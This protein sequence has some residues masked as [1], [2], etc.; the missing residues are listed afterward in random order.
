MFLFNVY[1]LLRERQ[2]ER[3]RERER[4]RMCTSGVEGREIEG[5]ESQ[6]GSRLSAHSPMYARL[7]LMN[8]EI[9]QE[10]DT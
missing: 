10:S 7:K 9:I 1:L 5:D 4:E 3:E 6:A 8:H 2:R